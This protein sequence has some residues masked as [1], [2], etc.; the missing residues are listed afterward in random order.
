MTGS[1]TQKPVR[2]RVEF[3]PV[4]GYL[5]PATPRLSHIAVGSDITP[6]GGNNIAPFASTL[7]LVQE[8]GAL[9]TFKQIYGRLR[10]EWHL[11]ALRSPDMGGG[12][13]MFPPTSRMTR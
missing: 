12:T 2:F 4:L 7:L 13:P 3:S 11:G 5:Q 1:I 8:K 9:S 10:A 6:A